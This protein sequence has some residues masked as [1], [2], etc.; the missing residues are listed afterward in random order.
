MKLTKTQIM[1]LLIVFWVYTRGGGSILPLP[2]PDYVADL[3]DEDLEA[4]VLAAMIV[5]ADDHTP[6]SVNS[7]ETEVA[8]EAAPPIIEEPEEVMDNLFP[9]RFPRAIV[10]TDSKNCAPC[11]DYK[12]N[13][14]DTFTRGEWEKSGWTMGPDKDKMIEVVDIS[15]EKKFYEYFDKL[16]TIKETEPSVP[17]TIFLDYNG[18]VIHIKFGKISFTEFV[19]LAKSGGV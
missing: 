16:N 6:K 8:Q 17:T 1:I 19:Q 4:K 10:L 7:V 18:K 14:L 11:K 15:D 3:R 2:K 5:I 12:R 9:G 13:T